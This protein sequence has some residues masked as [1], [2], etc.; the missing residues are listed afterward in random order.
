VRSLR[1]SKVDWV[2]AGV[3]SPVVRKQ[4]L[5]GCCWAM[6]TVASVEALHY[7]KTKQSILLSVQQLI[8]CDT[9]NNGCIGGHSDVALDMK[10]CQQLCLMADNSAGML[11]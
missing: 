11:S 3:V 8:D 4:K 10:T 9:K 1:R 5:C 7:M 2:E 6:A